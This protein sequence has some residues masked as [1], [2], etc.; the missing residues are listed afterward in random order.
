MS[1]YRTWQKR[2]KSVSRPSNMFLEHLHIP[3]AASVTTATTAGAW[4]VKRHQM[5]QLAYNR[6]GAITRRYTQ[7]IH[8]ISERKKREREREM[9]FQKQ[10][11]VF[12]L[13]G[14]QVWK[15]VGRQEKGE[16]LTSGGGEW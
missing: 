4:N 2:A 10:R 13:V 3:E 7:V 1:A 16:K 12:L 11:E 15:R 8:M 14:T 5:K 6:K 9:S